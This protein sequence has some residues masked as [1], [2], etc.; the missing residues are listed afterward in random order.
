MLKNRTY[1]I[2]GKQLSYFIGLRK[3]KVTVLITL[4]SPIYNTSAHFDFPLNAYYKQTGCVKYKLKITKT[5][6]ANRLQKQ[7][8]M[9][10]ANNRGYLQQRNRP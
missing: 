1:N 4:T 7:E 8:S 2:N 5:Y 10:V 3:K 6:S 9:P